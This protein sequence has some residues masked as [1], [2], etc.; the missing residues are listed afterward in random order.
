MD[1]RPRLPRL[2]P[3]RL[4]DTDP[5]IFAF[6]QERDQIIGQVAQ[7]VAS[8]YQHSSQAASS[9]L[10]ELTFLELRRFAHQHDEE[11]FHGRRHYRELARAL[12]RMG[13][14]EL[15][16]AVQE[17][18]MRMASDVAGNFDSRVYRFACGVIP[19]LLT[20]VMQPGALPSALVENSQTLLSHTLKVEGPR[21]HLQQLARH[22]TLVL[23]PT[24]SSNLDSIALGQ[25]LESF[26]LPPAVYG[27]GKNLFTNPVLGFFMHNLGAY[28]VDRR[29]QAPLYKDVLKTYACVMV[30]RGY[31]SLFF[32][33]GTRSRSGMVEQRLKL[34]LMGSA[35]E[36]FSRA[37]V[38]GNDLRVFFVPTTINY[39][40]VLE[41]ETLIDDHLAERGKARYIIHDDESSQ[42]DRMLSF[43]R[44]LG[45]VGGACIVRFGKP[46]DPFGNEVDERGRSIGPPGVIDPRSYVLHNGQ[47]RLD[48]ARDAAYTRALGRQLAHAYQRETVLMGTQVVAHVLFRE[49]VRTTPQYDLFERL[50]LQHPVQFPREEVLEQLERTRRGLVALEADNEARLSEHVR[51]S[52]PEQLLD[53]ALTAWTGYH[54]RVVARADNG[55]ITVVH[56]ELLLY[57]QNRLTAYA[58]R[59][60]DTEHAAAARELA[61]LGEA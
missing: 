36:A 22:G 57:Y 33:G 25:S 38:Q 19:R 52:T 21:E 34:G 49:L 2:V 11:A 55:K 27:A 20:G 17:A 32:P 51:G 16:Q 37:Q 8:H 14:S 60:A 29:V 58:D 54:R 5:R 43:L 56:P 40:L 30:E 50:R 12:T 6:N 7:R 42:A 13:T 45:G 46:T 24:H 10:Q 28:R 26:G 35:V 1:R 9:T 39:A 53:R 4:K 15:Q 18:A 44:K 23:V 48:P 41:A 61:T 31:H 3:Q 59:I 47:P